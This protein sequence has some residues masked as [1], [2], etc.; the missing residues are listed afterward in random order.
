MTEPETPSPGPGAD[1]P[2]AT[3]LSARERARLRLRRAAQQAGQLGAAPAADVPPEAPPQPQVAPVPPAEVLAPEP[4]A[5]EPW[6]AAEEVQQPVATESVTPEA[7]AVEQAPPVHQAPAAPEP[8]PDFVRASPAEA[9]AAVQ[10]ETPADR[11]VP[12]GS[13]GG[14]DAPRAAA[15]RSRRRRRRFWPFLTAILALL[16]VAGGVTLGL[17]SSRL[18]DRRDAQRERD[19]AVA[20]AR[21]VVVDVQTFDYRNLDDWL[22][23]VQADASDGLRDDFAQRKDLLSTFLSPNQSASTG[24]VIRATAQV[25][26]N[27][28]TALVYGRGRV[29]SKLRPAGDVVFQRYLVKLQHTGSRWLAVN[30]DPVAAQAIP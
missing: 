2:E 17:L 23:R 3:E 16:L 4:V 18:A 9:P 15:P 1:P 27:S 22:R 26:G 19:Q 13:V 8:A 30:L 10:A 20:A 21:A 25:T 29:T 12:P 24:D 11:E 7:P 28:A 5:P 14:D 6:A